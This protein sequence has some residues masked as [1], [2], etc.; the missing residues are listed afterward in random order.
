MAS[1][2]RVEARGAVLWLTIDREARRNAINREVMEALTAGVRAGDADPAIRALVLTG[3]GDKAFCAGGDLAPTADGAPFAV[4]W[5]DPRNF[6][7]GFFKAV[8]ACGKPLIA[9]VNGHA[10][11]GGLGLL[12]ACD[13]AVTAEHAKFGTPESKV[14]LYPMM[15]LPYML[16]VLPRRRLMEFC[17]TG[18]LFSAA[19]A[20]DFGLVNYVAPA[21]ELDARLDWLLARVLDKSPTGVRLGKMAMRALEDMTLPQAFEYAQLMLPAMAQTEDAREGFRAF[22]EKRA[23]RFTGK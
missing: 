19:E 13:L 2:V 11:A 1:P 4:D 22:N 18:E 17:I 10:L 9:R 5:A 15:I 14:G 3:A 7:V 21:G 20:L 12:C 6:V 23:P 8:E 16:R